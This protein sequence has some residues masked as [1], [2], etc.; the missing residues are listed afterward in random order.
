M[1][2]S[3]IVPPTTLNR[4]MFIAEASRKVTKRKPTRDPTRP[5]RQHT[6]Y[7]MYVTANYESIKEN[8]PEI[9]PKEMISMVARQWAQ[10]SEEEK[11]HWKQRAMASAAA[12]QDAD[13]AEEL[14]EYVDDEFQGE[15]DL[16]KKKRGTNPAKKAKVTV[17]V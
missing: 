7:T 17:T 2:S 16:N 5:K 10:V 15:D 6:A 3:N 8:N 9:A 11:E 13:V 1:S 4:N 14:V 12:G